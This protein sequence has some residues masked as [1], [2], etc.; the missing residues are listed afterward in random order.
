MMTRRFV[1]AAGAAG[2]AGVAVSFRWAAPRAE[3]EDASGTFEVAHSDSEWRKLLN[4]NQFAVL[5]QSAT[6]RPFTSELLHEKRR[7]NFACVGC[8][9]DLF[10]SSTKFDSGTG[11]PSFWA[12]LD[13]AVG[14]QRDT[15]FGMVDRRLAGDGRNVRSHSYRCRVAQ[16]PDDRSIRGASAERD[17]APIHQRIAA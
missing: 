4:P 6:E 1:L 9:L 17:G 7:G 15:S 5:R 16:A 14:T 13:K 12:P 8:D 10:A 3:A 11:W 2:L